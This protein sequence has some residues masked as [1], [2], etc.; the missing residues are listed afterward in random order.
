MNATLRRHEGAARGRTGDRWQGTHRA[1]GTAA[2]KGVLLSWP[3][4]R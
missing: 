3:A 4:A 2:E 1:T